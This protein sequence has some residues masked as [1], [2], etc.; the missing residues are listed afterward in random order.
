MRGE[1]KMVVT[2]KKVKETVKVPKIQKCSCCV[3]LWRIRCNE[4]NGL[5]DKVKALPKGKAVSHYR[6]F[7]II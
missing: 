7:R 1:K 3:R 6:I 5:S 2:L 4:R